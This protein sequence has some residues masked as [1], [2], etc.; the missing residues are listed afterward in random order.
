MKSESLFPIKAVAQRTG[1]TPYVIRA[2]ERRYKAI[3]PVRT[4]TNRRLYSEA[5][6]TRLLLLR[7]VK[8]MGYSIGQ[9]AQLP[10]EKLLAILNDSPA[11]TRAQEVPSDSAL[12]AHLKAC[13]SAVERFDAEELRRALARAVVTFGWPV[14]IERVFLP[15]MQEIGECWREGSLRIGH[16]HLAS[17]VIQAFL[18]NLERAQTSSTTAPVLVVTTPVGQLH[19]IGALAAAAIATS[20]GWSVTYLGPNLPAEEIAHAAHRSR[21]RAVALSIVYPP[22]DP[23]L[24]SE[25]EKLR[26]YLPEHV[27]IL[28]GGRSA[29]AYADVLDRIGAVQV[30]DWTSFRT[31]LESLRPPRSANVAQ[32]GL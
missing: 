20:E 24:P 27:T 30:S 5:D 10:T 18:G 2:W 23:H 6:I 25:L 13:L 3:A 28:V 12:E 19:E 32:P 26:H 21:A 4:R 22:D 15:L 31:L 14:V 8:E 16:E 7:R 11:R 17:A 1:L 29:H 9:I